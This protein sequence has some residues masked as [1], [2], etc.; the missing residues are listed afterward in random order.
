MARVGSRA[1]AIDLRK[2]HARLTI[3]AASALFIDACFFLSAPLRAGWASAR[4][5][6]GS[7][8]D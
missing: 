6:R 2:L 3:G 1:K 4:A 7:E 8:A 5:V